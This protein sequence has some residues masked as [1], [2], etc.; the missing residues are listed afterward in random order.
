MDTTRTA[1]STSNPWRGAHVAA[2]TAFQDGDARLAAELVDNEYRLGPTDT[3]PCECG[4]QAY[5][6]ATVGAMQCPVCRSLY[7]SNG[8]LIF[9]ELRQSRVPA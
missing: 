2:E 6:R 1:S 9:S 7:H 8:T 3:V 4:E 5:W